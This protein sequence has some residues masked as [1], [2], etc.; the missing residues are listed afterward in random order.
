MQQTDT[1]DVNACLHSGHRERMRERCEAQSARSFADHELLEAL[2]FYSL[3][4]VNTNEIAHRLL[5]EFGSLKAVINAPP[6]RLVSL[7]GVGPVT[8]QH[9]QLVGELYRRIQRQKFSSRIKLDTLSKLG[10]FAFA[11]FGGQSEES[12]CA[13]MLDGDLRLIDTVVLMSGSQ[14][15]AALDAA[16]LAR[17]AV[18]KGAKNVVLAHNHPGGVAEASMQDKAATVSAQRALAAVEIKLIEHLI[19]NELAYSPSML[20][21]MMDLKSC[22]ETEKEF[23]KSFYQN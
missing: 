5:C 12:L 19:V 17:T 11:Y 1:N 21:R 4:R 7:S 9:F 15:K 2:L 10:E 8:A 22:S 13:I 14:C 3:P 16:A 18:I 6:E 23:Y 20:Y